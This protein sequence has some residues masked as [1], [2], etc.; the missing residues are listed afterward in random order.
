MFF[1]YSSATYGQNLPIVYNTGCTKPIIAHL[2]VV[3]NH[4]NS[5]SDRLRNRQDVCPLVT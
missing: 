5:T 3:L 4:E 2:L 1:F